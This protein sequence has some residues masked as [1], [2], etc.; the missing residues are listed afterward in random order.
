MD[1]INPT[2]DKENSKR[3]LRG[4]TYHGVVNDQTHFYFK[5]V[6]GF[7]VS[8]RRANEPSNRNIDYGSYGFRLVRNR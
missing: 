4:D 2:L 1:A 3:I 5:V 8:Y 7:A 6:N